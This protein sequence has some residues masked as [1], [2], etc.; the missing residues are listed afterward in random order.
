MGKMM[1]IK[2]V[3][4]YIIKMPLKQPFST[5]L[6]TVSD[7]E[8]II[9]EV[10]DRDGRKGYGEAVAFSTPWYTEETIK[11]CFHMLKDFLI[12]LIR[13]KG[14]HHPKEANQ[15]FG[16]IRRNQMAKAALETALWD[17]QAKK[18]EIA[19]SVMLG[20]IRDQIPSGAVVGAKTI[21]GALKQVE[22][23]LDVGYQRL[24]IK[25]SPEN[26]ITLLSEIRRR[27]PDVPLMADANSAYTLELIPRLKALDQFELMMIEQPLAHDDIVDHARLQKE[28]T[29]PICL[30]ESIVTFDDARKAVEMGSCKVI[31]IKIGR[32][33][34]LTTAQAIHDFCLSRGIQ[35]WCGGMLEFGVSRA[36]NIAL[37]TLSGFTIPGDISATNRYWEEDITSP[38]VSVKDGFIEVP[39]A[40]GIG[41]EINLKRIHETLVFEEVYCFDL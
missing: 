27:F 30:D 32:V 7:R 5:H 33:G 23:F 31:N 9:V 38:E 26:D 11:T 28:L 41:Y 25:I 36:H 29:T 10:E 2:K 22:H 16:G 8:A 1:K 3:Q 20:G 18:E 13:T 39:K 34:G 24:K 4:L 15:L 14:I 12:P 19:L 40:P 37:A 21:S 17:L 35:V 6:G